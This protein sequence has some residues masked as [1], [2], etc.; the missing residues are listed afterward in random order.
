MDAKP[1][2]QS[3]QAYGAVLFLRWQLA[4]DS[5]NCVLPITIRAVRETKEHTETGITSNPGSRKD[6]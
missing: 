1:K 3:E 2:N 5:F 4:D 6:V